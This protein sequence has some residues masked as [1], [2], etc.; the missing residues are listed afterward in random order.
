VGEQKQSVG[1]NIPATIN[2]SPFLLCRQVDDFAIGTTNLSTATKIHDAIGKYLQLP[3]EPVAP[4]VSELIVAF[5][6]D[7]DCLQ[8]RHRVMLPAETHIR[9]LLI[10]HSWNTPGHDKQPD[11]TR[12]KEP[13]PPRDIPQ[14]YAHTGPFEDT[15]C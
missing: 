15:P 10:S 8:N 1:G 11:P 5:Y 4:F 9:R 13:L 2:G 6:N 12:P 3:N 7:V 14:L